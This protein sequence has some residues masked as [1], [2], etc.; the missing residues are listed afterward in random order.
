MKK[1]GIHKTNIA[2]IVLIEF[3]LLLAK[4]SF[5]QSNLSFAQS[6]LSSLSEGE[7]LLCQTPKQALSV[8]PSF[9]QAKIPLLGYAHCFTLTKEK[10]TISGTFFIPHSDFSIC[11][12]GSIDPSDTSVSG[13]G[14]R[15]EFGLE[16]SPS[17]VYDPDPFEYE[18]ISGKGTQA[19]QIKKDEFGEF[20]YSA[21]LIHDLITI[22]LKSFTAVPFPDPNLGYR[23]RS[24]D[25][26]MLP[27]CKAIQ[28]NPF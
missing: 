7:H 6:N 11:F 26:L 12:K 27:E 10:R 13:K 28:D 14:A 20:G 17:P 8:S 19:I 3:S 5:A 18:L 25:F 1:L 2:L 16:Q 23:V 9:D 15:F 24:A 21:I 4:S 22:D